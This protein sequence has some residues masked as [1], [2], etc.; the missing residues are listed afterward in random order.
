MRICTYISVFLFLFL[1]S[2]SNPQ[3]TSNKETPINS[4]TSGVWVIFNKLE[5]L[6]TLSVDSIMFFAENA[7]DISRRIEYAKGLGIADYYKAVAY[8]N[9]NDNEKA[10]EL[11]EKILLEKQLPVLFD[12]KARK[13]LGLVYYELNREYESLELFFE[14]QI[15]F[16]KLGNKKEQAKLYSL[17]GGLKNA[18]REYDQA[19][20]YLNK[21]S[22]IYEEINHDEGIM[23]ND[24]NL[25]FAYQMKDSFN[26]ASSIYRALIPKYEKLNDPL[27]LSTLYSYM[28]LN[29]LFQN[30]IDSA[31]FYS[32]KSIQ[33]ISETDQQSKLAAV[34]GETGHIFLVNEQYDSASYY[35]LK[36]IEFAK[37]YDDFYSQKQALSLLLSIDTLLGDYKKATKRFEEIL[38]VNDSD[39]MHRMRTNLENAELNLKNE[40]KNTFIRMQEMSLEKSRIQNIYWIIISI[41]SVLVLMLILLAFIQLKR[42]TSKSQELFKKKIE[43]NDAE[44]KSAN[45]ELEVEKLKNANIQNEI[46][47]KEREQLSHAL[48]LEKQNELL[49]L[50]EKT[51]KGSYS[52][53]GAL[54]DTDINN[55]LS[56]IKQELV[57]KTEANLFNEKFNAIH[58]EFFDLLKKQIPSITKSE[59]KYCAFVKLR[60]DNKQIASILNVSPA[61]IKKMRY[62]IRKKAKLNAEDSLDDFVSDI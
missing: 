57:D 17:I 29:F 42:N 56:T 15:L 14:S 5:H 27:N 51:L 7:S 22:S 31:I 6:E 47:I 46:Q 58:P 3:N 10:S 61:A 32:K 28:S 52:E 36:S 16:T 38:L 41:L 34:Y 59:L 12:A 30:K 43:L 19:I 1:G 39:Y 45:V 33:K 44:L 55:I 49:R 18:F 24:I 48:A 8:A 4:D 53:K 50:I 9:S 11:L 40:E 20:K 62:R 60:L 26:L 37:Q 54:T 23:A 35:F 21:S 2:C 25:A 13:Q